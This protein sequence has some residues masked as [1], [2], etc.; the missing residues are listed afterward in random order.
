MRIFNLSIVIKKI[1]PE[2][3]RRQ[4]YVGAFIG[5]ED[6]TAARHNGAALNAV[7][8]APYC[9][10]LNKVQFNDASP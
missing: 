10:R 9:G 4:Q 8:N 2:L 3:F 5:Q 6:F 1:I 7:T